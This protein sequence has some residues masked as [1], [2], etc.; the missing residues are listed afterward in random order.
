LRFIGYRLG[1]VFFQKVLKG[2]NGLSDPAARGL[3]D[4]GIL[5]NWWRRVRGISPEEIREKLTER[6]LDWHLNRY[7]DHDPNTGRSYSDD[8]PFI[9][10]TAGTYE[11]DGVRRRNILFPA[12]WTALSFATREF[13]GDGHVFFGYVYTLGKVSI[14]L[15]EFA[16]E[17]R[18]L[19]V[20]SRFSPYHTQGEIVAK[21]EIPSVRLEKVETYSL[22]K[23][24]ADLMS[25]APP[26]PDQTFRNPAFR[27]PEAYSN[28]R[29]ALA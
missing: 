8:T 29:E 12:L 16:E 19:N 23:L 18:D 10:T 21:I 22:A 24:L 9:S 25:G 7:D 14:E 2:I 28:I 3:L 17:V 15:P 11:R 26:T 20:Y 27:P 4:T 13:R 6:N 1:A 5:C